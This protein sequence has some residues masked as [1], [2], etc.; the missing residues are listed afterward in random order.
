MTTKLTGY[1]AISYAEENN[2]PLSKYADPIE[3]ARGGLTVDEAQEVARI[4]PE[5]IYI[6][7]AESPTSDKC[8]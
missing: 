8:L 3:D 5:L 6:Y 2:L 1:E 4:D 7:T